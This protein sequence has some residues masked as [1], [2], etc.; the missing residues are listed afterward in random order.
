VDLD[1]VLAEQ[2]TAG[3]TDAFG[4]LVLRYQSRIVN[5]A[6]ALA[7][8]VDAE[9]LAQEAFIRA[10]RGIGR[11]RGDSSFKTWLYRIAINVIRSH[12]DH[13]R[14]W[15]RIWG[16]SV[17][18]AST[19]APGAASGAAGFD[20]SLAARDAIDRALAKLPRDL[21]LAVALR[22]VQGLEYREIAETLGIPMGTVESRIFRGRQMLKPLLRPLIERA[23]PE[24]GPGR[25]GAMG[26]GWTAGK[27]ENLNAPGAFKDPGERRTS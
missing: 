22:D 26:N 13:R 21:R 25:A 8:D 14:R 17:D 10:Y 9:D 27:V 20:V 18:D 15:S 6:R 11:F 2:A 24:D 5:L 1:R 7:N 3:N 19:G 16:P 23:E 12:M 4:E